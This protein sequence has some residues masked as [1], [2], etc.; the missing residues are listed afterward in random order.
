VCVL[1]VDKKMHKD[2]ILCC[3]RFS[4][5]CRICPSWTLFVL[6]MEKG[7]KPKKKGKVGIVV[8]FNQIES[9]E[10]I[11]ILCMSSNPLDPLDRCEI[12]RT[13]SDT[14]GI[15]PIVATRGNLSLLRR[16]NKGNG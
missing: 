1:R 5:M 6:E 16:T 3:F 4:G 9:G 2:A 12:A 7:R 8:F 11:C 15:E 13:V 14:I 10:K